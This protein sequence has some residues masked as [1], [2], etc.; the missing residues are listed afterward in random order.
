MINKV[1]LQ[2]F[3][4]LHKEEYFRRRESGDKKQWDGDYKWDI[5]PQLNS[6][7]LQIEITPEHSQKIAQILQ[8]NIQN[9]AHWIDIDDLLTLSEHQNSYQFFEI[10]KYSTE[11]NVGENIN[12]LDKITNLLM[13]DKKFAPSTFGYM[14][15]AFNCS[16]FSLYRENIMKEIAEICL[17]TPPKTKGERY[18]LLN[19]A[20]NFI[21]EI[22]SEE[23]KTKNPELTALNGQDFLWT[24]FAY[25]K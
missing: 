7:L 25:D 15:T 24:I 3:F 21:G 10:I 19:D 14:L 5:L 9:F 6:H 20:V 18:K 17:I 2:N 11:E 4:N 12:S 8:K 23:P 16:K 13:P 22:M 1:A